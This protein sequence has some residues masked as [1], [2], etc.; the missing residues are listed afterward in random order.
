[1][2]YAALHWRCPRCGGGTL[3]QGVPTIRETC[4]VCGLDLSGE[5][6]GDGPAAS[7]IFIPGAS[8]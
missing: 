1:V 2:T 7:V 8:W 3:F 6:A 4:P 5:D